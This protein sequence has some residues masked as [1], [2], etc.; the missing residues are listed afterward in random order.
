[1]ITDRHFKMNISQAHYFEQWKEYIIITF[2]TNQIFRGRL[3]NWMI[4]NIIF[5]RNVL[6]LF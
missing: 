2:D 6:Y 4:K 3:D 1:M 5:R